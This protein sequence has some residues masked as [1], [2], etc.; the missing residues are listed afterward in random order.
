M[1]F[2]SSQVPI[3]LFNVIEK[4]PVEKLI[5]AVLILVIGFTLIKISYKYIGKAVSKL[6][7]DPVLHGVIKQTLKLILQTA[8]VYIAADSLDINLTGFTALFGTLG[9]AISLAAKDSIADVASGFIILLNKEFTVG[10]YVEIGKNIGTIQ[11]LTLTYIRINTNDNRQVFLP[12]AFVAKSVIVNHSRENERRLEINI[13]IPASQDID[14]AKRVIMDVVELSHLVLPEHSL[15][16]V[17]CDFKIDTTVL[18]LK[19]WTKT[20]DFLELKYFLLE[21]IKK[22]FQE[23]G[24]G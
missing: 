15:E 22:S 19:V 5:Q 13:D 16:L 12:N 21:Q 20:D 1:K 9:V 18:L 3:D 7:I 23:Q 11:K 10:D 24:I 14:K 17:V 2:N 4:Q 8:V 6:K